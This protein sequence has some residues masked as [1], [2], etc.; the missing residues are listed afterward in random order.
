[1]SNGHNREKTN[2]VFCLA[3]ITSSL[4]LSLLGP[5]P[6]N[7]NVIS[8]NPPPTRPKS[9]PNLAWRQDLGRTNHGQPSRRCWGWSWSWRVRDRPT[10]SKLGLFRSWASPPNSSVNVVV[11]V[12]FWGPSGGG[13]EIGQVGEAAIEPRFDGRVRLPRHG[14]SFWQ[15]NRSW[16][17]DRSCG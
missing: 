10:S 16:T 17:R 12:L 8:P 1:M 4:L 14:E 2:S 11:F 9:S 13:A 3:Y 15:P 7:D 6:S 5:L